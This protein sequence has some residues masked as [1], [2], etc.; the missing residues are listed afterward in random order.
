MKLIDWIVTLVIMLMAIVFFCARRL[1]TWSHDTRARHLKG[2]RLLM[3]A[4]CALWAAL[5]GVTHGL[6]AVEGL[7]G[8]RPTPAETFAV[9]A[10]LLAC[11]CYWSV[12]GRRLLKPR[13]IFAG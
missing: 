13:R 1:P 5:L 4:A 12:R 11:G 9:I 7:A 8:I 3:Q 10:V 2:T 6:F